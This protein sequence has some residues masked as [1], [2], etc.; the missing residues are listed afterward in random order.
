MT[1]AGEEDPRYIAAAEKYRKLLDIYN[2]ELAEYKRQVEAIKQ[3]RKAQIS[4]MIDIVPAEK[5]CGDDLGLLLSRLYSKKLSSADYLVEPK[6]LEDAIDQLHKLTSNGFSKIRRLVFRGHGG[7]S[8]G[9]YFIIGNGTGGT[10]RIEL[11]QID[12]TSKSYS[13]AVV[14]ELEKLR[15][16]L[17]NDAKVILWSCYTGGDPRFMQLLANILLVEVQGLDVHTKDYFVG[18]QCVFG[19]HWFTYYPVN[20][21]P[22]PGAPG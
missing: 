4:W 2:A 3:R 8:G 10:V 17:T 16:M 1:G 21:V 9:G 15:D 11:E 22:A 19:S 5:S 13:P 12:P 7:C 18:G 6:S 20:P 14:R